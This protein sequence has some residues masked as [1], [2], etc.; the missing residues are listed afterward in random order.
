MMTD[1]EVCAVGTGALMLG[2]ELS[3]A[4][5]RTA[6]VEHLREHAARIRTMAGRRVSIHH[7]MAED[8]ADQLARRIDALADGI[9]AGLHVADSAERDSEAA[10]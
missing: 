9:V 10:A 3:R 6:V 2:S 1:F 5:E 4:A 8:E 7:V